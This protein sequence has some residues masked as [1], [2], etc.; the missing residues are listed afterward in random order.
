MASDD[1]LDAECD[2]LRAEVYG[3]RSA[4]VQLEAMDSRV[5]FSSRSGQLTERSV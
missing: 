4:R 1:L 2:W 5:Q 3:T